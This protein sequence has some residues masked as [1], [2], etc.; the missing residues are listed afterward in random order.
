MGNPNSTALRMERQNL[1]EKADE[2]EYRNLYRD[3]SPGRNVYYHGFGNPPSMTFRANFND[4][5][6]NR[7]RQLERK[8]IKGR[9]QGDN[10]GWIEQQDVELF[11]GLTCKPMTNPT[12]SQ[13][14]LLELIDREGPLNIQVMKEI[15]G[16]KVKEITPILH[17]L[18]KAF[19]VYE[20]QYDGEWDRGWYRFSEMFPDVNLGK[21]SRHQ[22]LKIILRRFAYRLVVFDSMMAKSFY[23][24]PIKSIQTAIGE[25]VNEGVLVEYGSGYALQSDF[26]LLSE[27]SFTAPRLI[28]ALHGNDFLVKS[29]EHWLKEKFN[30]RET[31]VLYYLLIGGEIRGAVKGFYKHGPYVIEDVVIDMPQETVEERKDEIVSAIYAVTDPDKSPIKRFIGKKL[32]AG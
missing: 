24:L 21:Y 8:I 23:R 13:E 30:D 29:N 2:S 26:I 14:M 15:T 22:A 4:I 31:Q 20:D 7:K 16:M 3:T 5:E 25:M 9:F 10:V 17:K 11:A 19:A 1:L 28:F 27:K 6:F 12:P 18:Q 32:S